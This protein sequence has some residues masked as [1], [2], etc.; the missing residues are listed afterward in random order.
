[1][2]PDPRQRRIIQRTESIE[3][4]S[5]NFRGSVSSHQMILKKDTVKIDDDIIEK[6]Y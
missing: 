4:F 6:L 1:M 3:I 5:A 2:H